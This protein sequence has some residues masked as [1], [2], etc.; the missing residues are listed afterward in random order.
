MTAVLEAIEGNKKE[1]YVVDARPKVNAQ[2]N[3]GMGM[4]YEI[5]PSIYSNCIIEFHNIANIHVMR[6]SLKKLKKL[7]RSSTDVAKESFRRQTEST[8]WLEHIRRVLACAVRMVTLVDKEVCPVLSHCMFKSILL[9]IN[10]Y[11]YR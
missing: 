2:V 4:G 6:D 7:C 3:M 9:Y 11:V 10:I 1:L 8:G 5:V